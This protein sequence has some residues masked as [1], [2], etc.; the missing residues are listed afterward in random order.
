MFSFLNT[1]AIKY[2]LLNK[3]ELIINLDR[4]SRF[5][6]PFES[7][8]KVYSAIILKCMI[9]P[10]FSK[11]D[12]DNIDA[13]ILSDLISKIWNDSVNKLFPNTP[14]NP[15]LN[16][17]LNLIST[18]P[19][20]ITD[21]Y[22]QILTETKLNISAVAENI[23]YNNAPNNLKL[24]ISANKIF[25]KKNPVTKEKLLNFSAKNKLKYPIQKLLIVEGITEEILLPVFAHKV[26]HNFDEQG[27]YVLGAGGKSKSPSIY[28]KLKNIRVKS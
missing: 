7:Y 25:N 18:I 23:D 16:K 9:E 1:K 12:L 19:F 14:D 6:N 24:L 13:V 26:N 17:V 28:M 27:V 10:K 21:K 8:F 11:K 15:E 5:K 20:K 22:T 4:L 3:S 2:K